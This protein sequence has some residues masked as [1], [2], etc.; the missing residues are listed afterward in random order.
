MNPSVAR[1]S[2]C[3]WYCR[4]LPGAYAGVLLTMLMLFSACSGGSASGKP[5]RATARGAVPVTVASVVQ[6]T[7]PV[8]VRAIGAVEAY[9]TIMVKS[10]VEGELMRVHF[11][12][13]QDV[14]KGDP[15]FTI[16][17]RPFEAA[18]R[19]AEANLA[20]DMAQ[21]KQAEANLARDTAQAKNAAVDARRYAELLQRRLVA[22]ADYDQ[23]RTNADALQAAVRADQAAVETAKAAIRADQAAAENAKLQLGYT[24]IRSPIDGRT[25]YLM[26]QQGNLVK[27]NDTM[28]VTINQISPIYVTFA[29]P[30]QELPAIQKYMAAGSL[31]VAANVPMAAG[32]PER[33]VLS[34]VDNAVDR[35]TGTIRLKGTFA[36][37]DRQLWPGQFVNVVLTLTTQP[38]A[39]VV[40]SQA[41]LSGQEGQHVFVVKPDLAVEYRPVSVGRSLDGETVITEGLQPEE[42]VVTDGQ[43]RLAPGTTVEVKG[44]RQRGE[45]TRS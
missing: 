41:V 26:I 28:L 4:L 32:P 9:S 12:E 24:A 36:N 31:T 14:K 30:E 15:L 33:G 7:V 44:G 13:G 5:E 3:R 19:Q 23:Q 35:A 42:T 29:V 34:F 6:K 38:N 37:A 8:Q 45:D 21:A 25:G 18:L 11:K 39:V 20:K 16:D 10:Q 27:A 40:P 17:P 1:N 2:R 22:Q 43:L